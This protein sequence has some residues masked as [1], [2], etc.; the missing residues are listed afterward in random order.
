MI[1]NKVYCGEAGYLELL[2]DVVEHGETRHNRTGVDTRV[3]MG[4]QIRFDLTEGFPLLTTKKVHFKSIAV[5][6]DWMLQGSGDIEYLQKHGVTIWDAWAKADYRPEMGYAE[7]ELGPVYGV[8]WRRWPRSFNTAKFIDDLAIMFHED[9]NIG[10]RF[11]RDLHVKWKECVNPIL[12]QSTASD[13]IHDELERLTPEMVRSSEERYRLHFLAIDLASQMN[14]PVDQIAQ[15]VDKL[16]NHREDRRIILSAWN[17][18]DIDKMKLPPC[19]YAAQF[20]VDAQDRLTCI[21]SLRSW[22]L[23]LGGPFNIAQY[24]LL[25]HVL[26]KVSGLVPYQVIY[27]GADAHVYVNHIEQVQLQASREIRPLP[28]LVLEDFDGIDSFRFEHAKIINYDPHSA[29]AAKVAV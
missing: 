17:V 18:G 22:D 7:G 6:L 16:K 1:P 25:T 13:A 27:N 14:K 9:P 11:L 29:I 12:A 23:F 10:I 8:Q 19:H 21:V 20:L 3:L 28:Q 2:T 26:A 15:I 24:A 5:E 4:P